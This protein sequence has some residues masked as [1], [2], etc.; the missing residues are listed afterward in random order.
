M[1]ADM[2]ITADELREDMK[3]YLSAAAIPPR[4][5]IL[6]WARMR[7]IPSAKIGGRWMFT[8]SHVERAVRAKETKAR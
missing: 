4:V 8:A 6:R 2:L 3:R 5:T 7:I 1:N